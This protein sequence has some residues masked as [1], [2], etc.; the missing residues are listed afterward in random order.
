MWRRVLAFAALQL[1]I[2]LAPQ[3]LRRDVLRGV[4]VA[5][6]AAL[7]AAQPARAA[8]EGDQLKKGLDGIDYLLNSACRRGR[9]LR[10]GS[11]ADDERRKRGRD[12]FRA[13]VLGA[14]RAAAENGRSVQILSGIGG[15][16]ASERRPAQTGRKRR[17]SSAAC[18]AR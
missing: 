12:A 10:L 17:S 2:A 9:R 4:A 18:R 6:F 13:R 11:A 16:E 1:S 15:V 7:V 8:G 3:H 14:R 5:P